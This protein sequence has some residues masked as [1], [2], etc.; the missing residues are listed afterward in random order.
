MKKIITQ[1]LVAASAALMF[2]GFDGAQAQAGQTQPMYPHKTVVK[3][4]WH[5]GTPKKVRGKYKTKHYDADLMM[6]LKVRSKTIWFWASGMPIQHGYNVH[7]KKTGHNKYAIR[8]DNHASGNYRG[9]KNL[10]I[11]AKKVGKTFRLYGYTKVFH[12]YTGKD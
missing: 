4:K 6:I 1:S 2:V 8:Y 10:K 11:S 3:A 9:D 12:K 5:K 7:Y